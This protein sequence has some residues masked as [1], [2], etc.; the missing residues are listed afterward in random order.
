MIKKQN[1]QHVLDQQV[2]THLKAQLANRDIPCECCGGVLK[3]GYGAL[4]AEAETLDA[5]EVEAA[6]KKAE[7]EERQRQKEQ[8]REERRC[9]KDEAAIAEAMRAAEVA[10]QKLD[11]LAEKERKASERAAKVAEKAA[12][13][14]VSRGHGHGRGRGRGIGWGRVQGQGRRGGASSQSPMPFLMELSSHMSGSSI[15]NNKNLTRSHHSTPSKHLSPSNLS[16]D[17]VQDTNNHD[18]D[19][20]NLSHD[21]Q[22]KSHPIMAIPGSSRLP[23]GSDSGGSSSRPHHSVCMPPRYVQ[24]KFQ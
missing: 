16:N 8:E 17:E 23:E 6:A 22:P 10:Q 11:Q 5:L 19:S 4:D 12:L 7:E 14:A 21:D 1:T 9:Q 15:N 18:S 24:G 20:I 2:H 3:H 13:H